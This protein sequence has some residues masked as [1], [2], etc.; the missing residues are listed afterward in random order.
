MNLPNRFS[1][2]F[3]I[4][5]TTLGAIR[6][7]KTLS[8]VLC[9]K[10]SHCKV[11]GKSGACHSNGNTYIKPRSENVFISNVFVRGFGQYLP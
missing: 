11:T 4:L 10:G 2:C 6:I 7:F 9:V 1:S 5:H 3:S 8:A